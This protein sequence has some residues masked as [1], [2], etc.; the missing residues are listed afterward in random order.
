MA[1]EGMHEKS[2]GFVGEEFPGVLRVYAEHLG[3]AYRQACGAD[4]EAEL[5]P[6]VWLA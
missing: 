2:E 6:F 4:Y 3:K 5:L 1:T